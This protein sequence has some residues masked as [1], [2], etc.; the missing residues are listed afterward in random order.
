MDVMGKVIMQQQEGCKGCTAM[1][2]EL[3]WCLQGTFAV[4]TLPHPKMF[5]FLNQ[6]GDH[7]CSCRSTLS[8]HSTPLLPA[9]P[10][11]E[12]SSQSALQSPQ[13][14]QN[15]PVPTCTVHKEPI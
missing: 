1:W 12:N 8:P 13:A 14:Q 10:K 15:I 3:S 5:Y 11:L 6:T 2:G 7:P 9:P 4:K